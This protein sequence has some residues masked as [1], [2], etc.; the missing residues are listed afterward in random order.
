MNPDQDR[1]KTYSKKLLGSLRGKLLHNDATHPDHANFDMADHMQA[2][3]IHGRMANAAESGKDYLSA[4]H[5][6]KQQSIHRGAWKGM[7]KD[8]PSQPMKKAE[9]KEPKVLRL[10]PQPR[11]APT[12]EIQEHP[13]EVIDVDPEIISNMKRRLHEEKQ[14]TMVNSLKL[15][16]TFKNLKRQPDISE[17]REIDISTALRKPINKSAPLAK[18]QYAKTEPP[19][20]REKAKQDAKDLEDRKKKFG[21]D[22]EAQADKY[23]RHQK[24]SDVAGLNDGSKQ[25]AR[26]TRTAVKALKPGALV[27]KPEPKK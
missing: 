17:P 23:F 10:Q 8:R 24:G 18:A 6:R 12:V 1:T 9:P 11:K 5:H 14:Q 13:P 25:R 16:Q 3:A 19:E 20:V 27:N 4:A 26:T 2:A 15:M 21:E 22:L 7:L